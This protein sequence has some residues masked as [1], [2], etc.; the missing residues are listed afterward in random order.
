MAE[1]RVHAGLPHAKHAVVGIGPGVAADFV[2]QLAPGR[3]FAEGPRGILDELVH[4]SSEEAQHWAGRL[5]RAEGLLVGPST[6]CVMKVAADLAARP[7]A[8]LWGPV[9]RLRGQQRHS[10]LTT[11]L[12]RGHNQEN[13]GSVGAVFRS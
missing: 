2:E 8:E 11:N 6:G 12:G 5:A 4:T 3:P 10:L 1:S 13:R 7:E 9:G